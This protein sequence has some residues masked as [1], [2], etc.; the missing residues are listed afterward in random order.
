MSWS[1]SHY[2][3]NCR[4]R[5]EGCKDMEKIQEGINLAH[6]SNYDEASNYL[7]PDKGEHKGGGSIIMF[8]GNRESQKK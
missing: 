1:L 5:V 2:C 7:G 3:Y 8:C 4:K 6:Q